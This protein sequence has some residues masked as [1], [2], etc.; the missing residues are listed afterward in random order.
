MEKYIRKSEVV[1][2]LRDAGE[3]LLTDKVFEN[4]V[5]SD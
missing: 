5:H 3:E 1:I 2:I 4:G